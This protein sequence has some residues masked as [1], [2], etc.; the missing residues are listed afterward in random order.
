MH[1]S[2]TSKKTVLLAGGVTAIALAF[3]GC[4]SG[5]SSSATS[6]AAAVASSAAASAASAVESGASEAASAMES[7][8]SEASEALESASVDASEAEALATAEP[9]SF[10]EVLEAGWQKVTPE[11]QAS[12]CTSFKADPTA[13]YKVWSEAAAKAANVSVEKFQAA[14]TQETFNTFYATEC[15]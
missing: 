11:Q 7:G 13:S 2:I 8:A 6:S 1:L 5:S 12:F 10:D 14:A 4:S 9:M 15:P 3:T